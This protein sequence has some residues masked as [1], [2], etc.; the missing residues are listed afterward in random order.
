[1]V[2]EIEDDIPTTAMPKLAAVTHEAAVQ[3]LLGIGP[4]RNR[5]HQKLYILPESASFDLL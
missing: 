1:M 4:F 2:F 3:R 5:Q